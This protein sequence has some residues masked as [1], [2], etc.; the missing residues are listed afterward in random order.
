MLAGV[1][2][3]LTGVGVALFDWVTVEVALGHV[4]GLPPWLR[5]WV[6]LLGRR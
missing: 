3:V 1:V 4:L 2:G 5:S 6:P